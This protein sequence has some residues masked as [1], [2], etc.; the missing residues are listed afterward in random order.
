[1]YVE[2]R[3]VSRFHN[4]GQGLFYSAAFFKKDTNEEVRYVYDCGADK[5]FLSRLDEEVDCYVASFRNKQNLDMLIL[6][7]LHFDHV[8]GLKTLL[9]G[10]KS[11]NISIKN[12]VLPYFDQATR[13]FIYLKSKKEVNVGRSWYLDF[14]FEPIKFLLEYSNIENITLVMDSNDRFENEVRVLD[15]EN[16]PIVILGTPVSTPVDLEIPDSNKVRK[17]KN[18]YGMA[19]KLIEFNFWYKS[20][21]AVA[22]KEFSDEI[23]KIVSDPNVDLTIYLNNATSKDSIIEAYRKLHKNF[24]DTSLCVSITATER[25]RYD[26]DTSFLLG[27]DLLLNYNCIRS[28]NF[29]SFGRNKTSV[30]QN[31]IVKSNDNMYV[32][33]QHIQHIS[34]DSFLCKFGCL[35]TGDITLGS[36][37]VLPE[38]NKMFEQLIEHY[39]PISG[40]IG[41]MLV[42]HHG[43]QKSWN[44]RILPFFAEPFSVIS[45]G[46]GN[47]HRHP[48]F[49]V[50]HDLSKKVSWMWVNDEK[51]FNYGFILRFWC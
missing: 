42:P 4:V 21:C 11:K 29:Y 13:A 23:K 50:T 27:D 14:V 10:L 3:Q 45:A 41:V 26:E 51:S 25:Y 5:S 16:L 1:M 28:R 40:D 46:I 30:E 6:S 9:D 17:I 33:V 35:L 7:H 38:K 47:T 2:I 49:T 43:S 31:T 44:P 32:Q 19:F 18:C 12:V 15:N 34:T 24:N 22:I 37:T 36:G 20:C 8:S 48:D 39:L